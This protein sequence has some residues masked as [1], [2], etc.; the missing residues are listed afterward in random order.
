MPNIYARCTKI[1][2]VIG[3]SDYITDDGQ[4]NR[5][6]DESFGRSDYISGKSGRQEEVVLHIKD[7]KYDWDFYA[8]YERNHAHNPGQRQNE[9]RE[10]I[11][12]LPNELAGAEKGTTTEEQRERLRNICNDLADAIVGPNHDREIAVHWNHARTNLHVHILYSERAIIKDPQIKI[13]KKDIWKDRV[14]GRLTE[15]GAEDAVLV[16]RKGDPQLNE[17]GTVKYVSEPLTAKDVRF[18]RHSFFWER[19]RAIQKVLDSYGYHLDIQDKST[20]FLSQRKYYKGASADYLEKAHAYNAEVKEYNA[21]VR[22]HLEIEPERKQE[23][24][25]IRKE[26]ETVVKSENRKE[27]KVSIGAIQAVHQM[28]EKVKG[29]ILQAKEKLQTSVG[30]WWEKSK[31]DILSAFRNQLNTTGGA[32]NGRPGLDGSVAGHESAV[33]KNNRATR[34]DIRPDVRSADERLSALRSVTNRGRTEDADIRHSTSV[35][36]ESAIKATSPRI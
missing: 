36:G 35:E 34:T 8:A 22:E 4:L 31:K 2:N 3:R 20:P 30:K 9:A 13:Y 6:P 12:A 32:S 26:I 15:A 23:Y 10:I 17:D 19:D 29:F 24:I 25:D 7:M 5:S 14:T 1:H 16:H 27:K 33:V 28:A 21:R 11:I 18:K